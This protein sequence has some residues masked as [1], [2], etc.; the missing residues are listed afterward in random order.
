MRILNNLIVPKNLKRK[1]H[2]LGFFNTHSVPKYQKHRRDPSDTLKKISEN[3]SQSRKR[4]KSHS[5]KK[6]KKGDPL[7]LEW[8]IFHVRGFGCVQ[9]QVP[10]TYGKVTVP[11]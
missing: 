2:L 10:S 4:G 1:G 6:C 7:A 11:Q 3:V 5:A 9:N 8:F